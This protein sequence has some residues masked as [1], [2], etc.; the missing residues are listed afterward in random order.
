MPSPHIVSWADN[1]RSISPVSTTTSL[2]S[3]DS[4]PSGTSSTVPEAPRATQSRAKS[5]SFPVFLG[6]RESDAHLAND[7]PFTR[8]DKFY[9]KDGNVTFLV[10][11]CLIV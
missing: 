5:M 3:I 11:A 10:R 7:D 9:F 4:I 8:H 6:N 2:V 1:E